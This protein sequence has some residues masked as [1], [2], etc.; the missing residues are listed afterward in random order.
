VTF[1]KLHHGGS[2]E[3]WADGRLLFTEPFEGRPQRAFYE[4]NF[5]LPAELTS[6]RD[7]VN[8]KFVPQGAMNGI[9]GVLRTLKA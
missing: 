9:Y 2:M 5:D 6:D 7:T 4:K 3:I 1:C 8:I